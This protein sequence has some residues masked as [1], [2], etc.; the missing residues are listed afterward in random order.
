MILTLFKRLFIIFMTS[1][2][3]S[4]CH[5]GNIVTE[6]EK[7]ESTA[8]G[9][10]GVYA[11]NTANNQQIHYRAE[12]RFP[13]CSTS[14]VIAVSAI[15]KNSEKNPSLLSEPVKYTQKDLDMGGYSPITQ[16]YLGHG[17]TI[18]ELCKATLEYSDNTAM[19]LLI[20]KLGGP[21]AVTAFARSIQDNFFRLDRWEPEL[22]T[23][24]P[25]DERD[26]TT[27]SAMGKSLQKLTLGNALPSAQRKKL[28]TWLKNNTTGDHR[29]RAGV[30]KTWIVGD[31]TGTGSYGTT[32]DIAII[33]PPNSA[34][35]I[36]VIYFTQDKKPAAPNDDVISSATRLLIKKFFQK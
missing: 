11:V 1:I 2:V 24:I 28:V 36:M 27:P 13:F 12:E 26:T 29:I 21:Q 18:E 20:K 7:L 4:S 14:K 17:M 31:K 25:G 33:W 16:K 23:A 9:R 32:N 34:P 6:L 19:N 35:I 10:L 3:F 8:G 5:A 22:N 15:L 30:P